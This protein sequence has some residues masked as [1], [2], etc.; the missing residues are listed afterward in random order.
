MHKLMKFLTTAL[1]L[2]FSLSSFASMT[3]ECTWLESEKHRD[4]FFQKNSKLIFS[5]DQKQEYFRLSQ[6]S[7]FLDRAYEPCPSGRNETCAF[8]FGHDADLAW[9]MDF[10]RSENKYLVS[11]IYGYGFQAWLEIDLNEASSEATV[12]GDDGDGVYF[13]EAFSC[14]QN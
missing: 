6:E 1:L 2:I 5:V 4:G 13:E 11:Q 3:Y 12:V 7:N 9:D 10:S 14:T 8:Y